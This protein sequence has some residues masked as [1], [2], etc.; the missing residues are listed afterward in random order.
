MFDAAGEP[1]EGGFLAE[2]LQRLRV[3]SGTGEGEARGDFDLLAPY[4]L[5]R[6]RGRAMDAPDPDAFWR[7]EV[8]YAAVG[9]AIERRTGVPCQPMLRMF[10]EGHGRLVLVAGRLVVSS[11][12]VGD[13]RRFGFDSIGALADAGERLVAEGTELVLRYPDVAHHAP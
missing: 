2:L 4:V 6:V 3:A 9:A 10:R 7:L 12:S 11:R 1:G 13:V 8:F 5:G